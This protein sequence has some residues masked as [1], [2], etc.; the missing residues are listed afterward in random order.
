MLVV[1]AAGLYWLVFG[2]F[3]PQQRN[4]RAEEIS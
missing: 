3:K 4:K 1:I 2:A